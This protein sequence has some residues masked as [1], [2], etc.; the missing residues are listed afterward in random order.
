M[1]KSVI[2]IDDSIF[3]RK[4]LIKFFEETMNFKIIAVGTDGME[5]IS[6][7]K[8][9]KPDLIT[10]DIKMPN[11]DGTQA[12]TKILDK[13][14]RAAILIITAVRDIKEL[15]DCIRLGAKSYVKKP[16]RLGEKKYVT[17]FKNKVQ[18]AVSKS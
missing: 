2:I 15:Q 14:P 6:L 13:H 11:M 8:K 3:T 4:I 16:I 7:Y 1:Q 17:D 5:A 18:N 10:M 12:I 9:H